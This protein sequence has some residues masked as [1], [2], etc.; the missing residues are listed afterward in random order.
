MAVKS[1]LVHVDEHDGLPSVLE[2]ALLV[3][4]RF[5]SH[6][7]GLHV[8]PGL[9]RM[10]PGGAE[11]ALLTTGEIIE[12][13]ERRDQEV[14]RRAR[15]RFEAFM[16]EHDVQPGRGLPPSGQPSACWAE[17]RA[18][19]DDVL[20]SLGRV[21]DLI[22]V[23]RP[24]RGASKPSV[25]ALEA[26]LFESGRPVLMAPPAAPS[27]GL[28]E[29]VAIAWNGSTETARTIALAMPFLVRAKEV[30]VLSVEEGMVAGPTAPEVARNLLQHDIAARTKHVR[31]GGRAVGAVIL[32]ECAAAGADLLIKGAYTQSRFR[33]M[34]LGGATSHIIGA[35]EL[36]V[37][38]AH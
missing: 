37:I 23:G 9:P 20:G 31:A 12:D 4:K 17:R 32:E 33:Q 28:G 35:A 11:G 10:I 19:G 21:F 24:R 29:S 3:A 5:G 27:S 15:Q 14:S 22:V 6:I 34:I 18:A 2:C 1:I 30:L 26:A 25:A 7:E 8:R 16:R 38:I 36:P 13:L